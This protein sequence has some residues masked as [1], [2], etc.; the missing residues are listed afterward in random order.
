MTASPLISPPLSSPPLGADD[1]S[2]YDADDEYEIARYPRELTT[3]SI[4]PL[5]HYKITGKRT[6]IVKGTMELE[7]RLI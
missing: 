4:L 1:F 5:D 2:Y 6:N 7:L 3:I